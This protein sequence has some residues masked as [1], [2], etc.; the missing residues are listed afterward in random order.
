M[1]NRE[2][3][4]EIFNLLSANYGE[5]MFPD[6]QK[7]M[8][9][10]VNLWQ[11]MF[12][13]DDPAEVL[14]AVK[15]C[16]ATLQFPPKI[17]DIKS[18]ISQNR[19]AGQ[20]TAMEAWTQVYKGLLDID[21]MSSARRL[22]DSLPPIA[23]KLIGAPEQL[24][25]W[26]EADGKV[27]TTVIASAFMRDYKILAGHEASYHALPADMQKAESWKLPKA[28]EKPKELKAGKVIVQPGADPDLTVGFELP[29][30]MRPTV[31]R[32]IA[33]GKWTADEIKAVC[34]RWG[35]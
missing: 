21:G 18:R 26:K 17:A 27:L 23:K 33:E 22:Y 9:N 20:P 11:V 5:K 32:M 35:L 29:P 16:I 12:A 24:L 10:V 30:Y 31:E 4:G 28:E 13:D 19:M 3:I 34:Y 7:K 2:N 1:I 14:V 15:D 6:D 25:D 8:A